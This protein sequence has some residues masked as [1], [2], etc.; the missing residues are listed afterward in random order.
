MIS[1]KNYTQKHL[2]LFIFLLIALWAA[3]F[4]AFIL[5]EVYDNVDDGLKDRKIAIIREAYDN[6][7]ILK[8]DEYGIGQFKITPVPDEEFSQWNRLRNEMF[9]MPYDQEMEPY[10]VLTTHFLDKEGRS[11]QL[12]IRT[13]TVEE[14]DL[15]I[16][17][18]VAL[19]VLYAVLVICVYWV[20]RI[21]LNRAFKPFREII[22]QLSAYR[23]GSKNTFVEPETSISEFKDLSKGIL[24]MLNDN[25]EVFMQQKAFIENASHELKTPISIIQNKID[26][27]IEQGSKEEEI[28][29]LIQIKSTAKRMSDLISSLLTLSKIEN[30]QFQEEES[31]NAN[32]IIDEM[33]E[34]A[35]SL[36]QYKEIQL[37]IKEKGVFQVEFNR[38]L[39]HIILTNLFQNAVKYSPPNGEICIE[40]SPNEIVFSNTATGT[41]LD[42]DKIFNRFYKQSNDSLS[43][44]LGLA[45]L[46]TIINND[47]RLKID[48]SFSN[49]KHFFRLLKANIEYHFPF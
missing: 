27:L 15:L 47:P 7:E 46:Q 36:V 21:V 48:Y 44:G 10:R 49:N 30:N 9:Y 11:Y 8:T 13:S 43:T 32:E 14:D 19:A 33:A 6:P 12:E 18:A 5:D 38:N 31:I 28:Q 39:F 17:L 25:Q 26:L 2:S 45:I 37:D 1:L 3:L 22:S 16:N 20:N 29:Q 4:Y 23:F 34:N 35:E 40:I 42:G 41:A 24:T